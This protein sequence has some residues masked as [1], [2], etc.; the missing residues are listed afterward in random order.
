MAKKTLTRSVREKA[1]LRT[2]TTAELQ[3]ATGGAGAKP[4]NL[5]MTSGGGGT[6]S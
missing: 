3:A 4:G 2:L 6:G 1:K 5:S